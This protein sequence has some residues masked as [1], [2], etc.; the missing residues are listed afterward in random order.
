M[1]H[2]GKKKIYTEKDLVNFGNYLL[3]RKRVQYFDREIKKRGE[4]RQVWDND[5]ANWKGIKFGKK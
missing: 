3:S 5:I 1:V 2:F 4:H